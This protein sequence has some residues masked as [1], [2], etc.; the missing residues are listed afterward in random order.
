[1]SAISPYPVE[2]LDPQSWRE[3]DGTMPANV[4]KL[5]RHVVGH[6]ITSAEEA[7]DGLLLT[8]DSGKKVRLRDTSDCCASTTLQ[9]FLLNP[10]RV[11][12][13]IAGVGTTGEYTLWHIFADAGDVLELVVDW[14]CGN[15]FY[16]FYGFDI[17][18][19]EA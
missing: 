2:T 13:V 9:A 5:A 4:D 7:P 12:H 15:P 14:T 18:V 11:D 19:E 8:L 16:Y 1:M 3:D 10:D 6:R 17:E